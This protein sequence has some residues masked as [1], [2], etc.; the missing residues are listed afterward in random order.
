MLKGLS[1]EDLERRAKN[2]LRGVE[3]LAKTINPK[4]DAF[5]ECFKRL[6]NES[7]RLKLIEEIDKIVESVL[8]KVAEK[9][10]KLKEFP[11]LYA[12]EEVWVAAIRVKRGEET[13][14]D[15][16]A[17]E[18]ERK[19][20]H[21]IAKKMERK[22]ERDKRSSVRYT[23]PKEFM[24]RVEKL[25]FLIR[26]GRLETVLGERALKM[27]AEELL[28]EIMGYGGKLLPVINNASLTWHNDVR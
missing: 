20:S 16:Y 28:W 12:D 10:R 24:N 18:M 11:I 9:E 4:M 27:K 8:K 13:L 26:K 7:L 25:K 1:L 15:F 5:D 14:F 19:Y 22:T 17:A 21:I 3:A 2:L 23:P 6:V